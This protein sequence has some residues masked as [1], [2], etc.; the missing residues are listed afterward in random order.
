MWAYAPTTVPL[1]ALR[2]QRELSC[3][4][5][6]KAW[7]QDAGWFLSNATARKK[8]GKTSNVRLKQPE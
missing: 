6:P 2:A 5:G 1:F 3:P 4:A 7:K 8:N